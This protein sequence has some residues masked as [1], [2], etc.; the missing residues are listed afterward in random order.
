MMMGNSAWMGSLNVNTTAHNSPTVE[1]PNVL[2]D[3]I[4]KAWASFPTLYPAVYCLNVVHVIAKPDN[5]I[6]EWVSSPV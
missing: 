4:R 3:F 6:A 5:P 1:V 2:G